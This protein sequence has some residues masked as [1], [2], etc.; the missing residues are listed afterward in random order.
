MSRRKCWVVHRSKVPITPSGIFARSNDPSTW[1]SF[2]VACSAAAHG[3]VDGLG[4]VFDGSGIAGIDLDHCL[5]GGELL[6]W[7][8]EIVS[9]CSGTYIEV[10]PSGTGLHIFGRGTVGT[11]RKR[12]GIE[13]YDRG[14]FFTVTGQRWADAPARLSNIQPVLDAIAL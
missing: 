12:D 13:V 2:A 4:F 10:S 1:R 11:G 7:A 3:N 14:R 8:A 9:S 5:V 6:P